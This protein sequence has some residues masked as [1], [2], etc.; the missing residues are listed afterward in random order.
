MKKEDCRFCQIRRC[1]ASSNCTSATSGVTAYGI[2]DFSSN[3][4]NIIIEC[5]AFGNTDNASPRVVT[6]YSMDLPVGEQTAANWPQVEANMDGLIDL[7]NTPDYYNV[8]ITS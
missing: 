7:A 1:E 5:F 3:T 2:R 4:T 6:N 8:G